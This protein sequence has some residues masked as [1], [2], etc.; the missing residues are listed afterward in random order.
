MGI[1]GRSTLAS[2]SRPKS[3]SVC[4]SFA[5]AEPDDAPLRGTGWAWRYQAPVEAMD[6]TIDVAPGREG[7]RASG[8]HNAHAVRVQGD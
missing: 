3:A 5:Q 7:G 8:S 2:A 4:S 6:G 1:S